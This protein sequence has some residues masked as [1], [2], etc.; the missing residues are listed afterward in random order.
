LSRENSRG[1]YEARV[2]YGI[3]AAAPYLH[4]G[5]VPSLAE[6]LKPAKDRSADFKVGPAYDKDTVGLAADQPKFDY[7]FHTTG[8]D[9][10]ASGNSRCGHEYG[11]TQLKP[12]EKKGASRISEDALRRP[13]ANH[14]HGVVGSQRRKS[15]QQQRSRSRKFASPSPRSMMFADGLRLLL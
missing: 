8:C 4:D 5:S 15:K 12:D 1:T 10:Q 3:W 2:L 14:A 11:T 9:K 7:T 6:L 13:P